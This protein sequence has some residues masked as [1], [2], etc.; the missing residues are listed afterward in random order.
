MIKSFP[1]IIIVRSLSHQRIGHGETT[2][3]GIIQ[4]AEGVRR[5][6]RNQ[7]LHH[8]RARLSLSQ[9]RPVLRHFRTI[10]IRR[11]FALRTAADTPVTATATIAELL[12]P[13]LALLLTAVRLEQSRPER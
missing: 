1:G 11:R 10:Q 2:E 5:N 7:L 8:R 12:A 3:A 13:L 4:V 6:L 9:N